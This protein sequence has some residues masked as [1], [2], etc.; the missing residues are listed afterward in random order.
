MAGKLDARA[1]L[2]STLVAVVAISSTPSGAWIALSVFVAL[3]AV[4]WIASRSSFAAIISR[5]AAGVPF[6]LMAALLMWLANGWEHALTIAVKGTTALILLALLVATTEVSSLIWA[7]RKLGAPRAVNMIAAM[8]LRY[9]AMLSEEFGR[10]SRARAARAG[11]PLAGVALFQVHG[12]Q[13]GLLLVRSWE[14]AERIHAAMLSRGFTGTMP[15]IHQGHFGGRD[16][17][18]TAT[19]V[20]CFITV[21]LLL[22]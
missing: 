3:T 21:R 8:M 18:F 20:L 1:K 14:R 6:V 16:I 2:A 12:N 4:W 19:A 5:V 15:E 10:M 22:A 9:V 17:A 11:G 7:I 13:T